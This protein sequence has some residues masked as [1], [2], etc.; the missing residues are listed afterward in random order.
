VITGTIKANF[1]SRIAFRVS[2][3]VDSRTIIDQ[4]G[5]EHLLGRGDMLLLPSGSSRV[6]R[7]HSGYIS[8]P[9]INRITSFLKRMSEPAYDETILEEPKVTGAGI[10]GGERDEMFL[11]AVRTVINEGKCSITLLQR[12]LQLGYARAARIVDMMEQEGVVSPGEGSKP[13]DVLVGQE[14]VDTLEVR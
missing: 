3:R 9:E 1:P 7:M 2:Q 8:E 4:Q 11:D 13:R 5:A 10:D 6:I 14:F 12:R